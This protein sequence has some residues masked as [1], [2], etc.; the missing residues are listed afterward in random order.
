MVKTVALSLAVARSFVCD[1][2]G[3]KLL[4]GAAPLPEQSTI[5]L[6]FVRLL[7]LC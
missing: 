7:Y 4:R 2:I 1:A 5:A 3:S 6:V